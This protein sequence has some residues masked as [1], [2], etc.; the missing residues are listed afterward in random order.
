MHTPK[1]VL[2]LALVVSLA[3]PFGATAGAGTVQSP[4]H[5][6]SEAR[7]SDH[8]DWSWDDWMSA[9]AD[10]FA[11]PETREEFRWQG[12]LAKGATLEIKGINGKISAEP[13]AGNGVEL[14]ALKHG[15]RNDP[16][17]VE[18]AVVEHAG[19]ITICAVYPAASGSPANECQPGEGGRMKVRRN[20]VQVDFA[21]KV[22]AGIHLAARTVN[23]AVKVEGIDG[24]VRARTVNGSIRASGSKGDVDAHTVNG[25]IRL[26]A[27]GTARA[28]TVNGSIEADLGR[29]DWKDRLE[30]ETVNG[31][32]R[33]SLPADASTDVHVTTSNGRIRSEFDLSQTQRA[34]RR[35]LRGTIGD[36]GRELRISTVNGGVRLERRG[37]AEARASNER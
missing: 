8:G 21:L 17:Q 4:E 12:T 31:S 36:G 37:A 27:G 29:A 30:F 19:G 5:H 34:T 35:E 14:V 24:D 9:F 7:H 18:I 15:R 26:E 32:V 2:P 13:A 33:V 6:G 23:G 28:E 20:D 10:F 22:P 1:N 25:A 16:K 11:G 3:L